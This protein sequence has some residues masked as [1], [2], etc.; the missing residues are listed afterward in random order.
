MSDLPLHHEDSIDI[1][2]SPADV[3]DLVSDVA[4]TGEWSPQ[5]VRCEWDE[6][7]GPRVGAH[8]TGFN[9][10]PGRSWRTRSTV[11]AADPGRAFAW[12][13]GDGFVRWGYLLVP[14]GD[15][16]TLT[17]HWAFL[18]AGLQFFAEKFGDDAETQIED[19]TRAAHA[20]IP[21]TLAAIK[22]I[23]EA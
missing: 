10:V 5:C 19:R 23:A 8:F 4:R 7:D 1:D 9:E 22:R 14:R 2:R 18:D 12:E 11:V 20:G 3:Y 13:V 16:T 6:G 15:G 17:E 21:Q